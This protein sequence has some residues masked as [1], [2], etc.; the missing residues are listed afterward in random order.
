MNPCL[1]QRAHP[2][3]L[4]SSD[5]KFVVNEAMPHAKAKACKTPYCTL[6]LWLWTFKMHNQPSLI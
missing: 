1:T 4:I 3:F 6:V 5:S 2:F